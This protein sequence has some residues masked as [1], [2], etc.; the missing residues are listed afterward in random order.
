MKTRVVKRFSVFALVVMI[1]LS[2]T[3]CGQS[4]T[5]TRWNW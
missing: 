5:K 2:L 3:A 1:V 4:G